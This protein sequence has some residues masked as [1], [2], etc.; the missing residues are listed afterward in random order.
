[1]AFSVYTYRG[2]EHI[3]LGDKEI[4]GYI[5]R[6]VCDVK[7]QQLHL[8]HIIPDIL[9]LTSVS[10]IS[11]DDLKPILVKAI[12]RSVDGMFH[13]HIKVARQIAENILEAL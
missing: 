3:I 9:S 13:I 1:M 12:E 11:D 5:Y 2:C 7:K 6:I 10:C 8:Y 4:D